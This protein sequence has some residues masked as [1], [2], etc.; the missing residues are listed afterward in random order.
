M[1]VVEDSVEPVVDEWAAAVVELTSLKD[2]STILALKCW[3]IK[4]LVNN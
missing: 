3:K 4:E 1:V 2:Y